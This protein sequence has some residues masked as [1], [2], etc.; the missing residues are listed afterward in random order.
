ML[1][2]RQLEVIQEVYKKDP[3]TVFLHGAVRTGK[4][5]L[6]VYLFFLYAAQY[7]NKTF[8][9]IGFTLSTIKR[10]IFSVIDDLFNLDI[11]LDSEN[12]FKLFDNKFVCAGADKVHSY[13][14]IRGFTA[15]G[16]LGNEVSLWH[17][18]SYREMINRCSLAGF[19]IFLD[20]NPDSPEHY[21]YRELIKNSGK[22]LK[23]GA[24]GNLSFSF[25]LEDNSDAT[26]GFL[27][28][29]Y[30]E[31]LKHNTPNGHW[32]NRLINGLWETAEGI[33]Y[34]EYNPKIH[35]ISY[36]R[37][38]TEYIKIIA[39]VDWGYTNNGTII[40]AGI[41]NAGTYELIEEVVAS[42]KLI[43]FWIREGKRLDR[44]YRITAFVCDTNR[45]DYIADFNNAGLNAI[46]AIKDV[47]AG[48]STCKLLFKQR[49]IKIHSDLIETKRELY[50]YKYKSNA[51]EEVEKKY[52]HLMDAMRYMIH[53]NESIYEEQ[54]YYIEEDEDYNDN[55]INRY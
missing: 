32:Y 44:K 5:Y 38:I 48:I 9:I 45:P 18:N 30:I 17:E 51:K 7:K 33:I 3:I 52:D 15:Q 27:T 43:D 25:K 14:S 6:A 40:V 10:N 16:A 41:T 53:T 47:Q 37:N 26:G 34:S 1:T 22:I 2:N 4:T 24:L 55:L 31:N 23:S 49:K 13:K 46:N 8:L 39:G 36:K 42:Q 54:E 12:S 35:D 20:A 21:L 11:R 29:D 19:K 28:Q 50:L